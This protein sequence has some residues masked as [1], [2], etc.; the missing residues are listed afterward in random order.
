LLLI[1]NYRPQ[2]LNRAGCFL[3]LKENSK[4]EKDFDGVLKINPDNEMAMTWKA[5]LSD[6]RKDCKLAQSFGK[7]LLNTKKYD[8]KYLSSILKNCTNY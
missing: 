2:L 4:A 3:K 5:S 6:Q 7:R 1:P 8:R